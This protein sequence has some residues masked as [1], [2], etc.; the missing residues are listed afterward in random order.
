MLR[1]L[2]LGCTDNRPMIGIGRLLAVLPIIGIGRL[3]RRYRPI[4]VYTLGKYKKRYEGADCGAWRVDTVWTQF[5]VS[6]RLKFNC[7]RVTMLYCTCQINTLRPS[8]HQATGDLRSAAFSRG[9]FIRSTRRM[10]YMTLIRVDAR[11]TAC[12]VLIQRRVPRENAIDRRLPVVWGANWA[13][14]S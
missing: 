2:Q 3:L 6:R 9:T 8:S 10:L 11:H 14:K 4:I 12:A 13:L 7:R 1:R 5:H